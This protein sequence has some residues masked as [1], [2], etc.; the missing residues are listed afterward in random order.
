MDKRNIKFFFGAIAILSILIWMAKLG[1]DESKTYYK[2]I[3]E[4]QAMGDK[5]HKIR[6]KVAG[7]VQK[8]SIKKENGS[9]LFVLTQI[10]KSLAVKYVGASPLPDTFID[11]VEA[12]VD[13]KYLPDKMFLADQVQ[14]KCAS[15]YE[16]KATV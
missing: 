14:A 15:K 12:V 9:V 7:I 5:S 1:Y 3:D 4:L 2:T 13:G 11:G 6:L 16:T 10:D 8:G